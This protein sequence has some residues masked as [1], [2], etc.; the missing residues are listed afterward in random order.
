MIAAKNVGVMSAIE[1]VRALLGKPI[2][3]VLSDGR[4]VEGSLLCV[5]KDMNFVLGEA[6]E[7]HGVDDGRPSI[8]ELH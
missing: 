5:D 6:H 1:Q 7:F 8:H 3:V 4:V 2:R